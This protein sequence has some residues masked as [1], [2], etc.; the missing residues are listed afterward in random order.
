[1]DV[2]STALAEMDASETAGEAGIAPAGFSLYIHVPFC[3]RTCPYCDFYQVRHRDE[4]ERAFVDAV[5]REAA[6]VRDELSPGERVVET[7]YWGGGTPSL[8]SPDAVS[9]LA[10]GLA[11]VFR[12]APAA[13]FTV[14]ANPGEL[15]VATLRALSAAGANR[16]SLGC[17]SFQPERLAFLGRWHTP[18]QN[19]GAVAAA[20]AEGFGNV[21][22]DLIFNL[23]PEFPDS[24]WQADVGQAVALAPEHLSLYGLT[25]E[26]RTAF[27]RRADRGEL[28]LLEPE[29]Y[30]DEYLWAAATLETE[31]F[32]HYETSSFARPGRESAHNSR[33]WSGSDYLG[34]GPA[35]HSC[36]AGRRWANV[37]SLERYAAGIESGRPE[38]EVDERCDAP[39]RYAEAV[40]LGLRSG[41]GLAASALR[42]DA[43]R[44]DDFRRELIR[45]DLARETDGRIV[46]TD[47]G[48]LVLDE[49]V[50][51]LL[52][53]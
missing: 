25:L 2:N 17:Q 49:V 9:R 52:A 46:L 37:R 39:S 21:S 8:L 34:L 14:E 20:R 1:M 26:P 23:P 38:R 32:D 40:Y 11:A 4:R 24:G 43:A 27:G 36:W 12:I 10:E 33:Y 41:R 3:S 35:A 50:A 7:V 47:H 13:E 42:G 15:P 31:G 53:L 29:A 28:S 19:R 44:L 51:R 16:L 18:E 30:A 6:L 22:L 48:H 45:A 5:I